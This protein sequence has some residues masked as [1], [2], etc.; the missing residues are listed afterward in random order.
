MFRP[1][2]KEELFHPIMSHV[3]PLITFKG[4]VGFVEGTVVLIAPHFAITGKHV[5][6]GINKKFNIS[7]SNEKEIVLGL[8]VFQIGTGYIWYISQ[9]FYWVGTDIAFLRLHPRNAKKS[10]LKRLAITVDPPMVDSEITALG[11]PKSEIHV[12]RNDIEETALKLVLTPTVSTGAV[13]EVHSSQRDP[14]MLRFPSFTADAVFAA[15]MSGGPVFNDKRELCGLICSGLEEGREKEKNYYSNAV[16]I[17]PRM[18]IPIKLKPDDCIPDGLEPN[19]S[20]KV[21]DLARCGYFDV[22]GHERIEFFKHE[23]GSDGVR[24]RHR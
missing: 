2:T 5:I 14:F 24:R 22:K 11:Y 18:I 10:P 17:W 9:I 1:L 21:L 4:D 6:E 19:K 12:K 23:N 16:S 3:S 13:S 8:Y 7:M 20:Y 15:G